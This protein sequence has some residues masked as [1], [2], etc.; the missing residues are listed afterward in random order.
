MQA[1]IR[2]RSLGNLGRPSTPRCTVLL[3]VILTAACSELPRTHPQASQRSREP[4][5]ELRHRHQEAKLQRGCDRQ[6]HRRQ[7]SD[8]AHVEWHRPC[9]DLSDSYLAHAPAAAFAPDESASFQGSLKSRRR[10]TPP[11]G[12]HACASRMRSPSQPLGLCSLTDHWPSV[13]PPQAELSHAAARATRCAAMPEHGGSDLRAADRRADSAS[14]EKICWP[15]P[16][17]SAGVSRAAAGGNCPADTR[18][19]P[20]AVQRRRDRRCWAN[21]R[22]AG[23]RSQ[24]AVP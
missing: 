7:P 2:F 22:A 8:R 12:S 14:L 19:R 5:E 20:G 24:F 15:P 9:R 1:T 6:H 21:P 3:V 18:G 13:S 4:Q 23:P 11:R 16:Q 17:G 10:G